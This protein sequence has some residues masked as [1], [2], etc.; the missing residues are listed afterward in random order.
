MKEDGRIQFLTYIPAKPPEGMIRARLGYR[1]HFTVLD[2]DQQRKL[3]DGIQEGLLLCEPKGAFGRFW[4]TER[5]KNLVRLEQDTVFES[6]NLARLLGGSDEVV[7][8]ASTVGSPIVERIAKEVDHGDAAFGLILDAVASET[9]DAGLDWMMEFL[10]KMLRKEG[11]K[12]TKHRYSPGYGDLPLLNQRLIYSLLNLER[13]ELKLTD[14]CM[15]IPEKSVLA[16]AGIE[17]VV[18]HE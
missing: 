6:R 18:S 2:C 11:K 3:E 13:L 14:Q 16:V 9:A 15:L 17:G 5:S 7:L 12:L 1:K 8:M 4:I 10:N